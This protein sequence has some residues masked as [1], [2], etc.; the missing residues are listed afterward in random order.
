M[1][2]LTILLALVTLISCTSGKGN[3]GEA[4][5]KDLILE[6]VS[7]YG[8]RTGDFNL[9]EGQVQRGDFFV[10]LLTRLGVSIADAYNLT[11]VSKGVFDLKTIKVGNSYK[12]YYTKEEDAR[13]AYLVYADSKINY[14]VFGV[15]D[16]MFVKVGER[17]VT[18]RLRSGEATIN[19]SLW[20]DVSA[21]GMS[22]LIALRL[23]EI[24]AWTIDFFGLQKGDSFKVLYE[25]LYVGDK[26]FDIGEIYAAL[27][28]HAGENFEA[29]R[30]VQ[31]DIPQYWNSKGENLRKAFLKAPLS[32]TRISSG[33]SYARRHPITRVVRPH[34]GVDYAAPR[35]TPVMSIGDGVVTQRVYTRGGGNQIKIKHNSVYTTAY[36]HLSGFAKGLSVGK[37]VRQ[38]EVIGYVGSTGMS[39]GPHLDFRVWKNG[40]PINPLKMKSPPADPLKKEN[41]ELFA[42]SIERASFLRDSIRSVQ[43]VDILLNRLGVGLEFVSVE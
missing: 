42:S 40:K 9:K 7:E 13:L 38:G 39:T 24:Y 1:K 31:D 8:F 33:F 30:F 29:Y 6:E 4:L 41:K 35:G 26:F 11:E 37:R 17:E 25:E 21:A 27:F 2:R 28:T 36:L 16:S 22:P 15:A 19:S 14:V 3:K 34:T 5:E 20:N 32:F 10:P 23:S 12:A 43:Y 18:S